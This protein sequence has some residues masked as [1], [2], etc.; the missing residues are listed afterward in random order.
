M[1]LRQIAFSFG[2]K[3]QKGYPTHARQY[4]IM[5]EINFLCQALKLC[6]NLFIIIFNKLNDPINMIYYAIFIFIYFY[7]TTSFR[8]RENLVGNPWCILSD[9]NA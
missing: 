4:A 1:L 5:K 7:P 6:Q 9:Q 8:P 3:A 2:W